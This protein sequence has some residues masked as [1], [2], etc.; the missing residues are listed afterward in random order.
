MRRHRQ[1]NKQ[2][3]AHTQANKETSDARARRRGGAKRPRTNAAT[4]SPRH[5]QTNNGTRSQTHRLR[6]ARGVRGGHA[7][8]PTSRNRHKQ[9]PLARTSQI[10]TNPHARANTLIRAQC[11]GA[12][13]SCLRACTH[14]CA[15]THNTCAPAHMC[16]QR[17]VRKGLPYKRVRANAHTSARTYVHTNT[18]ARMRRRYTLVRRADAAHA[19]SG[20]M[21][22]EGTRN[23]RR[24]RVCLFA[25]MAA[26]AKSAVWR[27]RRAWA[28]S[29][30]AANTQT[31]RKRPCSS[32]SG[33]GPTQHTACSGHYAICSMKRIARNGHRAMDTIKHATGNA[34]T[35]T[36]QQTSHIQATYNIHHATDHRATPDMIAAVPQYPGVPPGT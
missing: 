31:L 20:C 1:T 8:N 17:T 3:D 30:A 36:A 28:P 25:A 27:S 29:A 22:H 5:K 24:R 10:Q 18:R 33:Q 23:N 15:R 11:T 19:C 32:V 26:P 34:H 2:T 14:E 12:A 4:E 35:R 21:T 16:A 7:N 9:T 6:T 13:Y